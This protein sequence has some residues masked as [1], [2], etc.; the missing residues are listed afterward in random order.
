MSRLFETDK[1][2]NT[3]QNHPYGPVFINGIRFTNS[4]A[5]FWYGLLEEVI[6]DF[7]GCN[8][9]EL[10]SSSS[11]ELTHEFLFPETALEKDLR[12]LLHADIESEIKKTMAELEIMGPPPPVHIRLLSGEM[13]IISRDLPLDIIDSE[14]FSYMAVWLLKWAD[15]PEIQWNNK[16]IEGSFCMKNWKHTLVYCMSFIMEKQHLSEGLFLRSICIKHSAKSHSCT[17]NTAAP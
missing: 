2:G 4:S 1:S 12:K 10:S 15:I 5:K 9:I 8:E 7:A 3:E 11:D 13:E 16:H 6:K 14:I 17:T